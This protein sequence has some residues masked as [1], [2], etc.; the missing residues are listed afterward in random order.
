M[1][2]NS[3]I[4]IT[5]ESSRRSALYMAR[6]AISAEISPVGAGLPKPEKPVRWRQ[7]GVEGF[8][9]RLPCVTAELQL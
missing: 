4:T 7:E 8:Q 9:G 1:L 3:T 6:E 5:D 2:A